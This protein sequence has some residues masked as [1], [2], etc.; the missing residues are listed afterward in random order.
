MTT[1]E[2]YNLAKEIEQTKLKLDSLT[3]EFDDCTETQF[4]VITPN[5]TIYINGT[6]DYYDALRIE[7][8]N[9]AI[10]FDVYEKKD[11][12]LIVNDGSNSEALYF[13]NPYDIIPF[14][15][16]YA[17]SKGE[18]DEDSEEYL[19]EPFD[20]SKIH[21][22]FIIGRMRLPNK[23]Y[24]DINKKDFKSLKKVLESS[25]AEDFN[26]L[27]DLWFSVDKTNQQLAKEIIKNL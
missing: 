16:K 17:K 13:S 14:L 8:N 19:Y 9:Y 15:L 11:E 2:L 24:V 4:Y 5:R 25:F 27:F 1:E 22:S 18:Y 26:K 7:S 23:I 10:D 21:S 3:S 20:F 12:C 6:S